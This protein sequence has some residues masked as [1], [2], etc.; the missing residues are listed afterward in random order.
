MT[1]FSVNNFQQALDYFLRAVTTH[2]GCDATVRSAIACCCFK[3]QQYDRARL[4]LDRAN[5][6][7]V[8]FECGL[9]TNGFC[10]DL[11]YL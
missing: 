10:E 11:C 7:D 9:L 2:P 1:A 5:N 8:S 3:L 4:A 6:I